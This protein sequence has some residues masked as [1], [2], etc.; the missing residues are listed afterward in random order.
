MLRAIDVQQVVM[1]MEQ[2]EKVQRVEQHRPETQQQYLA[3]QAKL[4]KRLRHEKVTDAEETRKTLISDRRERDRRSHSEYREREFERRVVADRRQIHRQVVQS[5]ENPYV[6]PL[7]GHIN[8][9][10]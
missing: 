4:E 1:Q 6:T 10:V 9:N 7:G 8:I 5:E 3:Q 2:A